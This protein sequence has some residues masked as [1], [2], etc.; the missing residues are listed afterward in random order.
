M[1]KAQ[2]TQFGGR[3]FDRVPDWDARNWIASPSGGKHGVPTRYDRWQDVAIHALDVRLTA[4]EAVVNPSPT[5]VP[6]S[7]PPS[8]TPVP[9]GPTPSPTPVPPNGNV[10]H[11]TGIV[12]RLDQGPEGECVGF[13]TVNQLATEPVTAAFDA[14]SGDAAAESDYEL[15]QKID[16]QPPD[17]QSGTSVLAGCKAAVQLG[18]L[19][20]YAWLTTVDDIWAAL[21][22]VAVGI[23]SDWTEGMM[24]PDANNEIHPDV[25]QVVGGHRYNLVGKQ[26]DASG[27]RLFVMLQSWGASWGQNGLALIPVDPFGGLFANQGEA[28]V[29][30]KA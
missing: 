30:S 18:W 24:N 28:V 15:A 26:V 27:N 14:R 5:P 8:P 1:P 12:P 2:V 17:E 22:S 7:P 29:F 20:S 25:G 3:T 16:G 21:D 19:K 4:V 6:P 23:G 13:G 9:P 11:V 10:L